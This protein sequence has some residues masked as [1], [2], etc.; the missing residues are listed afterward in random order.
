MNKMAKKKAKSKNIGGIGAYE[1]I[2]KPEYRTICRKLR[3]EIGATLPK[4]TGEVDPENLRR[5]LR[6]AGKNISHK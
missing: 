4:A 6:K 5:W 1:R 3:S 2:Q